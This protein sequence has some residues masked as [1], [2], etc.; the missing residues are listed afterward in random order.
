MACATAI[1]V[2]RDINKEAGKH[3]QVLILLLARSIFK[4]FITNKTRY[5]GSDVIWLIAELALDL[6]MI[7]GKISKEG[8][9]EK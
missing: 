7:E 8:N 1:V 4:S 6:R 5:S 2:L 3:I 9:E